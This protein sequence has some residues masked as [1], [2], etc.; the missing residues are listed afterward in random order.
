MPRKNQKS[1]RPSAEIVSRVAP[2]LVALAREHTAALTCGLVVLSLAAGVNLLF[3]YLIKMVLN[4]QLGLSIQHDMPKLTALLILLFAVQALFFYYRHFCFY[5][6]GYRIVSTLRT[7]LFAAIVNQDISYFDASRTGDLLSRLSSDTEL[8]QRAVTVNLSVAIRYVIQIIGGAALMLYISVKL[9]I[10]VLTIVP[11]L[12]IGSIFWG[13]KLKRLSRQFQEQ[14]GEASVI[15]EEAVGA[16]R[17]VKVFAGSEHEIK[18]YDSAIQASLELGI[19]RT[20]VGALFSSAM[21]FLMHSTIALSILFGGY[22]VLNHQ[23]SLADLTAFLLYCVIVA[24][25]LGFLVGTWD[26]FMR[27]VGGAERI[28]AIIDQVPKIVAPPNPLHLPSRNAGRVEFEH[29]T[30]SYPSRPNANVLENVSFSIDE[31]KTVALVGPS[32]AG[33]STVGSLICRFYDP[34]LG[35]ITY[36]GIPLTD[37]DPCELR[38]DISVVAQNP[39]VFS[40]SLW[41]NFLY[42]NL[43]AT[44]ADV[45]AATR[46]ANIHDFIV[47]LPKG[48]DT[49]VGD[50]G[51]LL[52]GGERQRVAIARALLKDPKFLILDEATSALDSEN[53]QLVQQALSRLMAG[54]T[55]LVIAHRLST[56]QN[57]DLVIVLEEGRICQI[58]THKSLVAEPGLYRTLVEH[59]VLQ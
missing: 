45:E 10:M 21:V 37:L 8:V 57:A 2:R 42:G 36:C 55:S 44:K 9:T 56:V 59:Q 11:V 43:R 7:K 58:G 18:R 40:S 29:I 54:R 12:V 23:L 39:Q 52:S 38:A 17:T 35:K 3:P 50:R 26:E 13:K 41:D 22:L 16:I 48:Y 47:S 49:L 20:R 4:E 32:G 15:A 46:A 6:V 51:I 31:G 33:K 53:E 25:S 1:E 30:F 24:V 27:A 19:Q 28:F 5:V 14:L 34:D